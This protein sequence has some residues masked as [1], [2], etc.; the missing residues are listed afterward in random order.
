M[1][2]N[3][4]RTWCYH[5][6]LIFI[7]YA[8]I[9]LTKQPDRKVL[10]MN[11]FQEIKES[12]LWDFKLEDEFKGPRRHGYA[13]V[14]DVCDR[15]PRLAI[16][17]MKERLSKTQTMQENQQPPRDMLVRAVEDAGGNMNLDCIYDINGEIRNWVKENLLKE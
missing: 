17:M 10:N 9:F 13:F 15:V 11:F 8:K 3:I 12:I 7:N 1:L 2:K 14:V 5:F 4:Q 16:Y 6:L